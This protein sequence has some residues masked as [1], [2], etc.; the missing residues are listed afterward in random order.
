MTKLWVFSDLHLEQS[1]WDIPSARHEFDVIVAAGDIHSPATRAVRWL[2]KR[3]EGRPVVF[4]PG[5]HEWYAPRRDF[6]VADERLAAARLATDLGIHL[7]MND[8]VVIDGVR[9]LGTTLWT[10]YALGGDVESATRIAERSMNDHRC[11]FPNEAMTPLRAA[12]ARE[13]HLASRRWLEERLSERTGMTTVVVTHH[14]PHPQSIGR[15]YVGDPLNPAFCSDLSDL[16]ET[17]GAVLWV[18]GHT[19]TSCDYRAGNTRVLCNPKGYGPLAT[20]GRIE[21][22][23]FDERL[24]ID[25]VD[26]A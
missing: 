8:Q 10:D 11:I 13:W 4:V 16:V 5:N 25:L 19:H 26:A 14:L 22:P 23:A 2:A 6:N 20:G 21:N 7:L 15:Q 9:F 1:A 12:T 3:A 18:H 17:S 24:M